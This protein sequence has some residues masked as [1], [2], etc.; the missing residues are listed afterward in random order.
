MAQFQEQS[1]KYVLTGIAPSAPPD[2]LPEGRFPFAQNVRVYKNRTPSPRPGTVAVQSAALDQTY[3]HTVEQINDYLAQSPPDFSL[4]VGAGNSLYRSAGTGTLAKI[5]SGYGGFNMATVPWRPSASPLPYCY[6]SDGTRSRKVDVNGNV[7]GIGIVPPANP[8]TAAIGTPAIAV[9]D[10]L[11]STTGW[12]AAGSFSSVATNTNLTTTVSVIVYDSGATGWASYALANISWLSVGA[13]ISVGGE[14]VSIHDIMNLTPAVA[15]MTVAAIAYDA[16]TTGACTIQPSAPITGLAAGVLLGAGSALVVVESVSNG[17]NGVQTFRTSTSGTVSAGAALRA[18]ATIRSFF[19]SNHAAGA[20]VTGTNLTV[21]VA[22]GSGVGTL[23]KSVNLNLSEISGRQVQDQ[24]Y[25]EAV[26]AFSVSAGFVNG[27]LQLDVSDGTFSTAYYHYDFTLADVF[28]VLFPNPAVLRFTVADLILA[29]AAPAAT[30]AN[31]VA[32]RLSVTSNYP[33]NTS[34]GI[35]S[36]S[37]S[38]TYG[39]NVTASGQPYEYVYTYQSSVTGAESNASPIYRVP[40]SPAN[41]QV[42]LTATQSSDPQADTINWYRRGGSLSNWQL[43]G[44]SPNSSSP[45]FTDVYTDAY[46]SSQ[47]VLNQDVFV[48]FPV[49][50]VP[51]SGTVNVAGTQATWASGAQ[52]NPA[53]AAGGAITINGTVYELYGSPTSATVLNLQETAGFQT[54]IAYT[55][56]QPLITG[57]PL[58]SMWGP[59]QGVMFACGDPY[60]PGYLYWTN[61]NDPDAC[62]NDTWVEVTSP[63]EPL[64]N[65][66]MYNGRAY[67]FSSSRMFIITPNGALPTGVPNFQVQDLPNSKGLLTRTGLAV[68]PVIAFIGPD[69]IYT[70]AGGA[71]RSLT[72]QDLR[73]LFPHEDQPGASLTLIPNGSLDTVVAPDLANNPQKCVLSYANEFFY[74]DYLGVNGSFYTLAFDMSA[75]GW[76]YD[77]YA[78]TVAATLHYSQP[79]RGLG[80]M[81]IGSNDG[82]LYWVEGDQDNG[83]DFTCVLDTPCFD[84]GTARGRAYFGDYGLRIK[85]SGASAGVTS[86]PYFDIFTS[87]APAAVNATGATGVNYYTNDVNPPNG[88]LAKDI[89]FRHSFAGST[90]IEVWD[91]TYSFIPQPDDAVSRAVYTSNGGYEGYKFVQGALIECD[92]EN[93]AKTL[94]VFGDGVL[95]AT[96]TVTASGQSIVP[97]SWTPFVA[98]EITIQGDTTVTWRLFSFKPVFDVLPEYATNWTTEYSG[99]GMTSWKFLR[100]AR[101]RVFSTADV[102]LTVFTDGV[103]QPGAFTLANTNGAY[104]R[105]YVAFPAMKAQLFQFQFTSSQ[106]FSIFRED[107]EVQGKSMNGQEFRAIA[108]FGGSSNRTGAAI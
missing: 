79:Q 26:F 50:D 11:D 41:E 34:L 18:Y 101:I 95:K 44:S 3:V 28:P 100:W 67:V 78:S 32:I 86:T 89:A 80:G 66:C 106:P 90:G 2:R 46:V 33:V 71:P 70:T 99:F 85:S 47:R 74:L 83:T 56:Q 20:A 91:A 75:D 103:Q 87:S 48:P 69:G 97:V 105:R 108:P 19:H 37:L 8:P 104:L 24:D 57:E 92:T 43:V 40:L 98:H 54:G 13:R 35:G 14:I 60:N 9:V 61:G 59:Y 22:S 63:S 17:P 7:Y 107:L 94:N 6:V 84:R 39:P 45:T 53:W 16:G 62:G 77:A 21:Q 73:L 27:S 51:H 65:G 82:H 23:T 102:T 42:L 12:T 25:F 5:D 29:G 96:V 58:P 38:G 55:F 15:G 72:A 76:F 52:F 30:L 1:V 68:G 88:I 4:L 81:L 10:E 36:W 31:V 49:Q 93:Q 64:I